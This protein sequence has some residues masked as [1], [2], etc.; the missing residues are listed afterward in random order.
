MLTMA[1][2]IPMILSPYFIHS[3][4]KPNATNASLLTSPGRAQVSKA[5]NPVL[6]AILLIQVSASKYLK[7][8][9]K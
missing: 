6:L 7:C 2:L 9:L 5:G 1:P 8:A 4:P 3:T